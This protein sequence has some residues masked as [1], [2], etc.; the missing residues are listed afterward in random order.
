MLKICPHQKIFP[1]TRKSQTATIENNARFGHS[2]RA[3]L[4]YGPE[5]R[6][7]EPLPDLQIWPNV[8]IRIQT[9]IWPD[10]GWDHKGA[11]RP[12]APKKSRTPSSG[13]IYRFRFIKENDFVEKKKKKIPA[14]P[15]KKLVPRH[16][17]F[18]ISHFK[19][20]P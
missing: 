9:L 19:K 17:I 14:S 12:Q 20:I 2:A 10:P 5:P 1:A 13:K 4:S 3:S 16:L 6:G 18:Y 8:I 15:K 7:Q 11:L